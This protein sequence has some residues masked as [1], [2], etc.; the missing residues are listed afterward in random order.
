MEGG[1][2]VVPCGAGRFGLATRMRGVGD[3][4]GHQP[5]HC[6][7]NGTAVQ[8]HVELRIQAPNELVELFEAELEGFFDHIE[9]LR[10][11]LV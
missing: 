8:G 11:N 2:W 6:S 3:V 4:K 5:N 7:T 9:Q 1:A 10:E